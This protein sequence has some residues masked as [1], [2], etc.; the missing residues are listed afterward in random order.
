[1]N[2]AGKRNRQ[3][4]IPSLIILFAILALGLFLPGLVNPAQVPGG[5]PLPEASRTPIQTAA[6]TQQI[7]ALISPSPVRT[8]A[9]TP[10]RTAPSASNCT[11]SMYYWMDRPEAWMIENVVIGTL[12]YTKGEAILILQTESDDAKTLLL[13][14]FFAALL[15]SLRADASAVS[16]TLRDASEWLGDHTLGIEV[17]EGDRQAALSMVQTLVEFNNGAI[18]PGHCADEPSTPTALPTAT[19]TSTPSPTPTRVITARP[20]IR[21]TA[22]EEKEKEPTDEPTQAPTQEPTQVPQ[23][24]NTEEPPQPTN[25]PRP[26]ATPTPAPTEEPPTQPPPPTPSA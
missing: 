18:G 6:S 11:Y 26:R 16:Q 3:W 19:A 20:T 5:G 13:Q 7:A 2:I 24:T 10:T 8:Q 21:P 9:S 12:S 14:Q 25:T 15:N 22:T 17:T 4:W 1:M 23:P